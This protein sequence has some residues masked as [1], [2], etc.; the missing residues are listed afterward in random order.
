MI[1]KAVFLVVL[2]LALPFAA[3]AGSS[4][5]FTNSGGTL[6][7][8][9]SALSL[10]GSTLVAVNGLG[11][12]L[13][14]GDNLGT[15][16]FSTGSLSVEPYRWV[17]R[18]PRAARSCYWKRHRWRSDRHNLQWCFHRASDLDSNHSCKRNTTTR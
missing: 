16:S 10:T 15:L 11:G 17:A 7:G 18:S 8:T 6:S 4:V 13:I 5:D 14:T 9:N 3:V 2:A 12:G 1:K